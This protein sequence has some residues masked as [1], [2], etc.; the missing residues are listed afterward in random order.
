MS[1]WDLL[2]RA[3]QDRRLAYALRALALSE[4]IVLGFLIWHWHLAGFAAITIAAMTACTWLA[5]RLFVPIGSYGFKWA[6]G[7]WPRA[8]RGSPTHALRV[9]MLE[10]FWMLRIYA[11]D[12]PWRSL[13]VQQVA[14]SPKPPLILVHGFLC[15][16]AIW[17]PLL[18]SG[19]IGD[20]SVVA[21]SLEPTYRRFVAQLKALEDCVAQV[22]RDSPGC[23]VMLVGHSMGGLLCRAFAAEFPGRVAGV[24]CIAAPHHGTW[25]GNLVYG[26]ENGPPSARSQWLHQFNQHTREC[27]NLPALN[28][29]TDQDNIVIPA[30]GSRLTHTPERK[31]D[32]LGHIAAVASATAVGAIVQA[33]HTLEAQESAQ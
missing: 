23:K 13:P 24:V 11:L 10:S 9:L 4:I 30:Q 32:G 1:T 17:R 33:I 27:I 22:L 8:V 7:D 3:G 16:A 31:L 25:F 19:E 14:Q 2:H 15:N 28:L 6:L 21:L 20:R 12:H 29:W 18:D 5:G 26:R